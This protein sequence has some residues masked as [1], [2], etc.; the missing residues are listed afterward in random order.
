MTADKLC[1]SPSNN[2][3]TAQVTN[4]IRG[5]V[6]SHYKFNRIQ[7]MCKVEQKQDIIYG[8]VGHA[9]CPLK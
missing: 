3:I 9:T 5:F 1:T 6:L 8:P 7:S 2:T 4:K